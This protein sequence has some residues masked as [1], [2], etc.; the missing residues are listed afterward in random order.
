MGGGEW[1]WE[2]GGEGSGEG[3]RGGG[4]GRSEGGRGYGHG[5]RGRRR[6][7]PIRRG[8]CREGGGI[9]AVLSRVSDARVRPIRP[10]P[11]QRLLFHGLVL[12]GLRRR[13]RRRRRKRRRRIR[14]TS[15]VVV[16][17]VRGVGG[18]MGARAVGAQTRRTR[19][20]RT[21]RR[22]RRRR[23]RGGEPPALRKKARRRRAAKTGRVLR[24]RRGH[25]E[26]GAGL[27]RRLWRRGTRA[28]V[29]HVDD[30]SD[31]IGGFPRRREG[32]VPELSQGGSGGGSGFGLGFGFG[33]G[34]WRRR[35]SNLGPPGRKT[36]VSTAVF[37]VRVHRGLGR[38]R[39]GWDGAGYPSLAVPPPGE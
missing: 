30:G 15:A 11:R 4:G 2:G 39:R 18:A 27:P 31:G 19:I 38:R 25:D 12:V 37:R 10:P 9:S 22:R 34:L 28:R 20:P 14:G 3:E 8:G 26:T 35:E 32:S 17:V 21:V 29:E 6:R 23:G 36:A 24:G 5:V 33:F 1:G 16:V 13:R 7:R